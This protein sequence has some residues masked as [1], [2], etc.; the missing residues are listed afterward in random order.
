VIVC[1]TASVHTSDWPYERA[2]LAS[3]CG[4][5]W[6][7]VASA[8]HPSGS[9]VLASLG[10]AG[11]QGSSAYSQ[12][13]LWGASAIPD[14]VTREVPLVMSGVEIAAL[15]DGF[16]AAAALAMESGLDG[17]EIEAGQ[18]SLLRQFRSGL[19]N[20][21]TD[22]YGRDRSLLLRTVL[23][24]VR[25]ALGDG[26]LGLRLCC[27]ELAPWAGITPSDP[28]AFDVD[29]VVPV[30]GSG[31]S[32]GA[33]RPDWHTAPGFN[34]ALSAQVKTSFDG[35]VVLQGSIVDPAMA[36]AALD[37]GEA[38]LVEMTRALVADPS[39]VAHVRTGRPGLI[40]PCLLSGRVVRDP[41]N[42]IVTDDA[43]PRSGHETLD[44]A[45]EGADTVAHDV[46]VV[47][48]G[49]AGMEA[50]RVLG[51]RGHRVR[52]VERAD[53]L[54]GGLWAM[55]V[56]NPRATL[57]VDWW[58]RE[59]ARAGVH[60]SL[61]TTATPADLDGLVVLATGSLARGAV[62]AGAAVPPGAVVVDDPVGDATGVTIATSLAAEGRTV[63]L[64]T[65]DPVAGKQLADVASANAR[66]QRA[67]VTR[68]LLSSLVSVSD[69]AATLEHV[70]TGVRHQ[71]PCDVVVDCGFRLPDDTLWQARP[72]LP[73]IG[74]CLAPRTI[75]EAVRE[76]RRT[77]LALGAH[78]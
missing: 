73:R 20:T 66:A 15:V 32:V 26:V 6:R 30:R 5:G 17:V 61:G 10:H 74:D 67:G 65:P 44:P 62:P 21:R 41:R 71:V 36:Q 25:T 12:R 75:H 40:R 28:V 77:A 60:V 38:D 2:P 23:T 29:Y 27:D 4:P 55:A 31:L 58:T 8:C 69:G 14:V 9:L 42:P 19:T 56:V 48:G 59:L 34:R 50:A 49:P 76:A 16:A 57:L 45:P 53:R 64:V 51:L 24:A 43:E 78:P 13:E 37:A 47:G 39:L 22:A 35:L 11:A 54:G 3:A 68:A 7:A 70:W 72:D 63:T 33:T 1:E 52:L 46:L 18:H